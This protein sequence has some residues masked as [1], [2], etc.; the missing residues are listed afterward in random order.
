MTKKDKNHNII[1]NKTPFFWAFM[2]VYLAYV[3]LGY[4]LAYILNNDVFVDPELPEWA[5][6]CFMICASIFTMVIPGIAAHYVYEKA[7]QNWYIWLCP[8]VLALM[9]GL[10]WL[11]PISRLIWLFPLSCD[12]P[13]ACLNLDL[14]QVNISDDLILFISIVLLPSI[15]YAVC[16]FLAKLFARKPKTEIMEDKIGCIEVAYSDDKLGV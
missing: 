5:I 3:F 10:L 2:I 16:I 13:L 11:Q 1:G 12:F 9:D 7:E 6:A 15:I 4:L 8:I 14:S